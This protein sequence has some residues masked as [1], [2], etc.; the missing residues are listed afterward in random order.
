MPKEEI[1]E[2]IFDIDNNGEDLTNWEIGF[3]ADLIDNPPEEYS[4]SQITKIEQ[5]YNQRCR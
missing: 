4:P 3:I 5:I 2:M 1:E